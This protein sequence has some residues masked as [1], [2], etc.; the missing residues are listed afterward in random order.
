MVDDDAPRLDPTPSELAALDELGG[1]G[2]WSLGGEE[3][4]LTN[5]DKVLFPAGPDRAAVTKRDLIRYQARIAPHLVP[6]LVGRPVNLHRYPDGVD[7]NDFWTKAIP[8]GAPSWLTSWDDP[9][10]REG[11]TATYPVLD[12]PAALAYVANLGALE[13]HPWTS[14][15][16]DPLVPSWA[17]V[18]ID[19][20]PATTWDDL[21][22]LV[23]LHRTALEQVG[24][25]GGAK[26]TGKR[27]IQVWIPLAPSYTFADTTAWVEALSRAIGAAVPDLVSWNWRTDERGG[28]ARLDFTQN[29]VGKTLVAPFST[30]P[31]A[32]APVSVPIGWDEL[33]DPDLRPDRWTIAT[34][35]ERLASHG[36]PLRPLIG[37]E[38]EL[39]SLG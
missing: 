8:K 28:R 29:A 38:Q 30:R 23:R 35:F 37:L 21:L 10:A 17:M 27:G 3:V 4:K 11:R 34:V 7:G 20:G 16:A 2:T 12:R 6:Y 25:L 33:E 26:V 19:P 5:L 15:C 22:V 31:A 39:P 24:L 32:G 1:A 18:D 13:I 14:T 9:H 36:D